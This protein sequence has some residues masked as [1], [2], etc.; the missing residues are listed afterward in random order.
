MTSPRHLLFSLSAAALFLVP[1][2]TLAQSRPSISNVMPTTVTAGV[3]TNLSVRVATGPGINFCDLYVDLADVGPMTIANGIAGL[4]YKIVNGGS[5]IA[6]VYCRYLD[7]SVNSGDETAIWANGAITNSAPFSGGGV[8]DANQNDSNQNEANVSSQPT[9][10]STPPSPTA[11]SSQLSATGANTTDTITANTTSVTP[12][13]AAPVA[14]IPFGSLIK[15][16]CADGAS[17]T[18]GCHAIY[19]YGA[20]GMRHA[21]ANS[22]VFFTWYSDFTSVTTVDPS[23]LGS[24]PLGKNVTYRPG[25]RMVKFTTDPRVYAV[26]K[27]GLLRW[28]ANEQ[29]ATSLYGTNWNTKIDDLSDTLYANYQFGEDISSVGDFNPVGETTGAAT[30]GASL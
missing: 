10:T 23:V 7:G 15:L 5:H 2:V 4:P 16:N 6:F 13:P 12:P 30:I 29:V 24:I 21:F 22:N 25:V 27:G 19:Y 9:Q 14:G 26:S 8:T 11:S 1:T 18:D 28:I 3:T 20:D 17:P